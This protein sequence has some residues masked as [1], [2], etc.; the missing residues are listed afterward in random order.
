MF[1]HPYGLDAMR[2]KKSDDFI[3]CTLD[4]DQ[5]FLLNFETRLLELSKEYVN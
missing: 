3:N 4:N 1:Y 2:D 5:D